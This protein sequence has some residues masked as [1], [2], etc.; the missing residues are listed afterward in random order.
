MACYRQGRR[1]SVAVKLALVSFP[2][3]SGPS[4]ENLTWTLEQMD[5]LVQLLVE[6]S[7]IP[8]MKSGGG[9]KSKAYTAIEKGMVDKFGSEFTKEK[10]K[11]KL[12]YSK[13]NLTVMKEILNT[14]GFGYDPINKC[15]EVDSQ[16]WNEYIQ[17]AEVFGDSHVTGR[18]SITLNNIIHEDID[19]VPQTPASQSTPTYMNPETSHSF[20]QMV[21][22]D[23]MATSSHP[24]QSPVPPTPNTENPMATNRTSSRT[25]KQR[26]N[27]YE[28][29]YSLLNGI[30]N[31]VDT[32]TRTS[33][34]V[35]FVTC[36]EIL[37]EM[38][39]TSDI[40]RQ[41][42]VRSMDMIAESSNAMIFVNLPP[43][44]RNNFLNLYGWFIHLEKR[45]PNDDIPPKIRKSKRF[46]PYF[47]FDVVEDVD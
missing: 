43:E 37:Q 25:K 40:D 35:Q 39:S 1:S 8:G 20:T 13:P 42:Q 2:V 24:P 33:K 27:N 15:I 32:M 18:K 10:I 19:S 22:D 28:E 38:V 14:S 21:N 34:G 41:T 29:Y 31:N 36:C 46:N 9:L 4:R 5:Y 16:V 23:P 6:Q 7:R 11:N 26:A 17:F 44:E 12:K 30:A 3:D 47:K 45:R